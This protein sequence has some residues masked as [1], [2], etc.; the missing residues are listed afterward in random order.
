VP[1]AAEAA[2][3]PDDTILYSTLSSA[4]ENDFLGMQSAT[5]VIRTML[6]L[7]IV[8]AEWEVDDGNGH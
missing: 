2:P 3:G 8:H 5:A 7:S 4:K 1:N 6:A